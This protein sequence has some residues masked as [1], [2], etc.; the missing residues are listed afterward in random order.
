MT[1]TREQLRQ[2]SETAHAVAALVKRGAVLGWLS[3]SDLK[4]IRR[5]AGNILAARRE[6]LD[7][8]GCSESLERFEAVESA[9]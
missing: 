3:T 5:E 1:M 4:A 2:Q 8:I 7:D 6:F 9:P